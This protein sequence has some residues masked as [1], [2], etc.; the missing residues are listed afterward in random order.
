MKIQLILSLL[1]FVLSF[2]GLV[3]SCRTKGKIKIVAIIASLV[4]SF[5]LPF[6]FSSYMG[7]IFA[8]NNVGYARS[9][10]YTGGFMLFII[11]LAALLR[12]WHPAIGTTL[13]ALFLLLGVTTIILSVYLSKSYFTGM[14][15]LFHFDRI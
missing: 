1:C 14:L 11:V 15:A 5:A 2:V 9:I 4:F 12:S 7:E 8:S 13:L 6:F 3:L 10:G